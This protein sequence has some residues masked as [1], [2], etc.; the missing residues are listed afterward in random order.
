[1]KSLI[2]LLALFLMGVAESGLQSRPNGQFASELPPLP[3]LISLG[4]GM[5]GEG[6]AA[7]VVGACACHS[8]F[9]QAMIIGGDRIVSVD[10]TKVRSVDDVSKALSLARP[11]KSIEFVVLPAVRFEG[12]PPKTVIVEFPPDWWRPAPKEK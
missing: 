4:L 9:A 6:K 1:M 5:A 8:P 7:P 2:A 12:S 3:P 10:G 11:K